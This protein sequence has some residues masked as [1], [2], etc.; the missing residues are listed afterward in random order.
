M[1]RGNEGDELLFLSLKS[2]LPEKCLIQKIDSFQDI[3]A[4]ILVDTVVHI[5]IVLQSSGLVAFRVDVD[6]DPLI[7]YIAGG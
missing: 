7:I 1:E 5:L 2:V 4:E 6:K 3:S